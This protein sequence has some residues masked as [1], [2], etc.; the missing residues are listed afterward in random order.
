MAGWHLADGRWVDLTHPTD[1]TLEVTLEAVTW[2]VDLTA[3][4]TPTWP[5]D[6]GD[7]KAQL[8]AVADAA[9]GTGVVQVERVSLTP[10]WVKMGPP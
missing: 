2:I 7:V 6:V 4:P 3:L 10:P 1:S 5:E 9:L 8:Q